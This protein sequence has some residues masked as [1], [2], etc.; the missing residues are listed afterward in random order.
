MAIDVRTRK[1]I[2][3][4]RI[5]GLSGPAIK[6]I[7]I[8]MVNQVY[9]AVKIPVIGMGGIMTGE[10]VA[11]FLIAGATAVMVGTANMITP[12]ASMTILDEFK[13]FMIEEKIERVSDL[14]GSLIG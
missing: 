10:D 12:D 9:N 7:A 11:E 6:P 13:K 2:L 4:N 8:R 1:P 5:G 14:T 3:A